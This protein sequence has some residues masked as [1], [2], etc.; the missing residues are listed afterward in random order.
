MGHSRK[1]G[2]GFA[3]VALLLWAAASAHARPNDV[4]QSKVAAGMWRWVSSWNVMS[5][6]MW[7]PATTVPDA[8]DT[9]SIR[10]NHVITVDDQ[11][12]VTALTIDA[13]GRL[14]IEGND[15]TAR[16]TMSS[17]GSPALVIN[18]EDGLRLMNDGAELRFESSLTITGSLLG[19]IQGWHDDARIVLAPEDDGT[20]TLE[21]HVAIHGA[22]TIKRIG[23]GDGHFV[24]GKAVKADKA[25][26]GITLH[27]SLASITDWGGGCDVWR[28]SATS[29]RL[30]F[31][32]S[33]TQ[34]IGGFHVGPGT[35][36]VQAPVVT[37]G[38]LRFKSGGVILPSP[39]ASFKFSGQ[40]CLGSD[41][42]PLSP[43]VTIAI[44][45]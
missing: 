38:D 36:L 25:G 4:Y 5:G 44:C 33:A 9:V 39:S 43:I 45:P 21:T 34:L 2:V 13:N 29:A 22:L 14:D 12:A 8:G 7:V 31:K 19:S 32:R 11:Q 28:V 35:L 24:N 27:A 41:C 16:L 42:C 30:V 6:G 15:A 17:V 26:L 10:S 18:Q 37:T 3:L 40:C 23:G 20:M 1:V